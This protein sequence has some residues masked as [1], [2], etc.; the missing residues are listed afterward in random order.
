MV[1][2]AHFEDI[3]YHNA[4]DGSEVDSG[5]IGAYADREDAEKARCWIASRYELER[6]LL[7]HHCFNH[8]ERIHRPNRLWLGNRDS[9]TK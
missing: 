1:Y 2:T 6:L 5:V 7:R 9:D 4:P 8:S 3:D